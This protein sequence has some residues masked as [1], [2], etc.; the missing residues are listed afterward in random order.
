MVNERHLRMGMQ[1]MWLLV[2]KKRKEIVQAVK[3]FPTAMKVKGMPRPEALCI[4][5]R[6]EQKEERSMG[7][8][9]VSSS[10]P[11][12]TLMMRAGR[13][14]LKSATDIG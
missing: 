11:C 3:T 10:A 2:F 1:M 12:L 9:R 14:L 6:E 5:L 13:S 4:P 8:S 7:I